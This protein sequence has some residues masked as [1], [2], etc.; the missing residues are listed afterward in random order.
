LASA[1]RQ[2]AKERS[3]NVSVSHGAD[4]EW[5]FKSEKH[6][7]ANHRGAFDCAFHVRRW[8]GEV[9][10]P[11]LSDGQILSGGGD[12]DH[13]SGVTLSWIY[14]NAPFKMSGQSRCS[15]APASA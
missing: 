7:F 9:K 2:I 1:K 15:K 14:D 11:N 12:I 6:V 8:I 5:V 3:R 4:G 10:Q 13:L